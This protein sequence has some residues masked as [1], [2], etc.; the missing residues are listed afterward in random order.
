M[1][2]L[3]D[4]LTELAADGQPITFPALGLA[5][6]TVASQ[7]GDVA[8]GPFAPYL[9]EAV[10][11]AYNRSDTQWQ[12]AATA[13]P[14]GLAAQGS[15]L[16]LTA[17]MDALLHSPAA[18]KALGKPL[19]AA[20]L[21]GLPDRI[22]AAPLLAA[23]RLEGAVRLAVAEAVTPFKLWQ[24]LEDVPTDGP[25]DF[26]ER[27]PR[28]LGLTLDRWADEDTIADTVRTLLQQLTH[29]EATDVD[30][31]FE[32]GCDL[33]RRA[34]SSQDIGTITNHLVQARRQFETAAQAE[35]ARH[36]A[37]TYAAVCDAILAFGRADAAAINHA[38]DQIAD[39]LDHRRAWLHRTHQPE[40][41]QPR[42]SSEI[43]W[44]H[45]VLQLRAAATT[46]QDDA[47][48]DAW[49]ALNTV[50]AAYSAAR[51]VR[52]L[53]G[54]TGQ[55]LAL[56]VQPAIEDGFLRQQ[57]FLAQLRRAA[58]ETD[59]HA[60]R[61]FDTATA[62]ALLTAIETAAQRETNS[63]NSSNA[64]DEGSDNDDPGGAALA[65]LQRLAPALLLQLKDQALSIASTL[66]DQQLLTLEGLAHD[67]DVARLK[68]T[69]PLIVPKLD[70]L[71]AELSAHP[72]FTGEV[73]QTFSVLVE[74]TL[75]FLKSRSDTTRTNLFGSAKKDEPPPFD[76]RRKPEGKRKPVEADLQR[77]FH[78]WLQKGPLHNVILVEPDDVGM[79][80]AD[81]MAHFGS[82]RYLTEIKQD[83]TDNDPQ[84]LESRYLAQAAEYSNTNAPFG[85]LL[86]LDLTSK[87]KTQGNLRVDEVA[88]ATTHR[89]RGAITDRAVVVGIV[90]GNRTTPSAYSRK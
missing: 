1:P 50:L 56:L 89:P 38:A 61:G 19:T 76:Y 72:S 15:V 77:D 27:L 55:G 28:L 18:A 51:T 11:H 30:A 12:P 8:A 68:A 4:R 83:A 46:L 63:A 44:H 87:D 35:E 37:L 73:R 23:A 6:D 21:D 25:E 69:D 60:A 7:A 33:L 75:L 84:Y 62:S 24:A 78:Q 82:L 47:W 85:Q 71:M 49:Q 70:Q 90:A 31:M 54:D 43:A 67:S 40:W 52:P 48:M 22:E 39:T 14:T 59:Q 58:Q 66:D 88:W 26:L 64:T 80:R 79:G 32:L 29:D 20:L 65:R 3:A 13:L 36:D 2:Q 57:A 9:A 10:A 74:Q 42:R 17:A 16:H 86:V 41:L 5:P 34:L 45:L 81:V 53:S